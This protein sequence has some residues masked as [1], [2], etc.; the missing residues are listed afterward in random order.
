MTDPYQNLFD[1]AVNTEYMPSQSV[2]NA[3]E[4]FGAWA[5]DSAALREQHPPQEL[6]YGHG[7]HERLDVFE[8]AGKVRA[9]LLFIHGGYWKAFYKDHFSYVA[10]PLL[11]EGVRVA[12]MSYDLAP[13]VTL[14]QIVRQAREAAS[15][16]SQSYP[17]PLFVSGHSAGGHLTAM[18]H[19]TDWPAEGLPAPQ[20]AGSI[21]ISGLYDLLPLRLTELQPDLNLSEDEARDLSPI[22]HPP[23]SPAPFIVAVG[24]LESRS[25]HDQSGKLTAA[26][27]TVAS[28]PHD[29]PGRHHFDAP[30]DLLALLR[31]LLDRLNPEPLDP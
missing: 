30:D 22:S 31:P 21:G 6:A 18:I 24:A 8:P 28:P 5:R 1:P 17:G 26:W 10:A 25:F 27:P 19:C 13:G 23:T 16:V 7:E 11:R 12:V 4:Y 29:L 15:L 2:P 9:T 20:L 14:R 3:R